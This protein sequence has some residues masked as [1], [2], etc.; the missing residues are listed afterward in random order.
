MSSIQ[1]ITNA[2]NGTTRSIYSIESIQT[3]PFDESYEPNFTEQ[4]EIMIQ[5]LAKRFDLSWT[6]GAL[7]QFVNA[8]CILADRPHKKTH[9]TGR[10]KKTDTVE[11]AKRTAFKSRLPEDRSKYVV[12]EHYEGWSV[13]KGEVGTVYF[14]GRVQ[15]PDGKGAI[16][17]FYTFEDACKA[18]EEIDCSSITLNESGY[19]LR[20][21]QIP[22]AVGVGK[23][24]K[25]NEISHPE[26]QI[27]SWAKDSQYP[28]KYS[29]T[30]PVNDKRKA[31]S[32]EAENAQSII[33]GQ[34]AEL[35]A[36]KAGKSVVVEKPTEPVA[37]KPKK[38]KKLSTEEK[39][40]RTLAKMAADKKAEKKAAEKK[41]AEEA[42]A[43]KKAEE[44]AA[45]AE[46]EEEE[47]SGSEDEEL[48]VETKVIQGVEYYVDD[49]KNVYDK[50]TSEKV[51]IYNEEE[52][53]IE[54]FE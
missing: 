24:S 27:M 41:A 8:F 45:A 9:S 23:K 13:V 37:E 17:Y 21:G 51:G 10:V 42:A 47:D 14:D 50:E 16:R 11:S 22:I 29:R 15:K 34:L 54:D 46:E 53:S 52:N 36:L 4:E 30:E 18:A 26:R 20:I 31:K 48:D 44:E 49:D 43:K 19:S 38:I 39:K 35:K 33:A 3:L 28:L 6:G 1:T 12:D 40:E 5:G 7:S 25:T 2:K 32:R